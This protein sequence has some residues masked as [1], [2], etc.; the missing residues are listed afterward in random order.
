M[1]ER[2]IRSEFEGHVYTLGTP[3][4]I[5]RRIVGK[6]EAD[7]IIHNDVHQLQ[8]EGNIVTSTKEG[9]KSFAA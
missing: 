1:T 5:P 2:N 7:P 4:K 8:N 9:Y 6:Q 3:D